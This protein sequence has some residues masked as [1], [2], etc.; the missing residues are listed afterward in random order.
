MD[1]VLNHH[2]EYM[3]QQQCVKK[4]PKSMMNE[5]EDSSLCPNELI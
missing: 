3:V 1:D 4:L 5:I 2:E